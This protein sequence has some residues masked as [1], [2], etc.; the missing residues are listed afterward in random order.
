MEYGFVLL[1]AAC[2][3][4]VQ[5]LFPNGKGEGEDDIHQ[6]WGP[7]YCKANGMAFA[8]LSA[9]A[10]DNSVDMVHS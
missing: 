8:S 5:I 10:L 3:H 2:W 6:I 7:N 9:D 4:N 1:W